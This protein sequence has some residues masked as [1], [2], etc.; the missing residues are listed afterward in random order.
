[1]DVHDLSQ[2]Q[3]RRTVL[4]VEQDA[5]LFSTTIRENLLVANREASDAELEGALRAV[6][7]WDWV[8]SLPDGLDTPVGEMGGRVSG[9]Q[10]RRLSLARAFLSA[11]PVLVLDEPTAHLHPDEEAHVLQSISALKAERAVLLISHAARGLDAADEVLELRDGRV[12]RTE[13]RHPA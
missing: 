12:R 9:G 2:E 5:H 3:V 4:L 10:R 13:A 11:A 8:S 6:A 7:A 1:V